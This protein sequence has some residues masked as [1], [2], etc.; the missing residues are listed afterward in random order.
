MSAV[1]LGIDGGLATTGLAALR[2][3]QGR[4]TVLRFD[5]FETEK[6]DKKLHVGASEDT[7]ARARV[8]LGNLERV[9]GDLN[10]DGDVPAALCMETL[11]LPRNAGSS[12]KIGVALGIVV[13]FAQRHGLPIVQA[14]PVLVKKAVCGVGTASK[15]DVI[16]AVKR[17]YPETEAWFDGLNKG[18]REHA[19]D[20][21]A[22]IRACFASEVVQLLRSRAA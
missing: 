13:A 8:L 9:L 16:K 21:V 1:L 2:L 5:V 3:E 15:D 12:A 20:A 19:A 22:V 7:V 4:E 17:L 10:R 18:D 11:S 14:S 6:S